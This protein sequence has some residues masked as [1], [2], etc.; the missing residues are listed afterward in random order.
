MMMYHALNGCGAAIQCDAT[1]ENGRIMD[2]FK[3]GMAATL[4]KPVITDCPECGKRLYLADL[5]TPTEY[6][7]Y[8]LGNV[9]L[10]WAG[11]CIQGKARAR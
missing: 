4:D 5:L 10:S 1:F 3:D 9:N 7:E 11:A 8:Q 2:V 6:S